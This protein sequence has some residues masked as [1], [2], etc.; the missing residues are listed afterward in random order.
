[1]TKLLILLGVIAVV[2]AGAAWARRVRKL[3]RGSSPPQLSSIEPCAHCGVHVPVGEAVAWRGRTYCCE[4]HR[5][6]GPS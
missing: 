5:A 6:K 2:W 1:M 4:A 3:G